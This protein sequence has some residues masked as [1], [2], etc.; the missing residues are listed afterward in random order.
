M[1]AMLT[2]TARGDLS[3]LD[4]IAMPCSVNAYG[5]YFTF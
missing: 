3:A 1:I 4:S 5:K 2:S